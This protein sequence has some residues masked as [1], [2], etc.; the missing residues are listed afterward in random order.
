MIR[1]WM[2]RLT[3]SAA[4]AITAGTGALVAA[5]VHVF[6][7]QTLT[8]TAS[9]TSAPA[10]VEVTLTATAAPTPPLDYDI[11]IDTTTGVY[12][13]D[14]WD[15]NPCSGQTTYPS[16]S[17]HSF[18]ATLTNSG[19]TVLAKSNTVTVSWTG[20]ATYTV[21]MSADNTQPQSGETVT[22]TATSSP[23]LPTGYTIDIYESA[24]PNTGENE[25]VCYDDPCV[26]YV[27]NDS[28]TYCYTAY[29]DNDP[30]IEY[31]PTGV[32]ATS[33]PVCV[34]WTRASSLYCSPPSA[35]PL[36]FT[37]AGAEV[38]L[39]TRAGLAESDVCFS[40]T[41][42]GTTVEGGAVVIKTGTL[43]GIPRLY[44]SNRCN[45][46]SG[47][48]LGATNPLFQIKSPVQGE[49]DAYMGPDS[50]GDLW[51]CLT[52]SGVSETVDLPISLGTL[53]S[54]SYYPDP[55]SI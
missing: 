10:G 5:P 40:I 29:V 31:P 12:V 55:G 11:E 53:P 37:V 27:T 42:G 28:G 30:N 4:V 6:A 14:C 24:G 48:T 18:Q 49:V 54:V 38:Y 15:G 50:G 21:T 3:L 43:P 13:T 25:A 17:S 23:N 26:T 34:T 36:D 19:G 20:T 2:R 7:A 32:I 44:A 51:V 33:T 1:A 8:L 47:N 39:A 35:P 41:N 46:A 22:L 52:V 16:T 45:G 9:T